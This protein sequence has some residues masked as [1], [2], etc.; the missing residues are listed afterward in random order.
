MDTNRKQ[1][2]TISHGMFGICELKRK[3]RNCSVL[4][5]R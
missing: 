1:Q 3:R 5:D 4:S 2:P